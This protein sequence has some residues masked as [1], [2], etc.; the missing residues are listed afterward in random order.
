MSLLP[1]DLAHSHAFIR[2]HR[3]E[4]SQQ[5]LMMLSANGG[6]PKGYAGA[7]RLYHDA[8]E[9]VASLENSSIARVIGKGRP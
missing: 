1:W 5:R 3:G 2:L 8:P 4:A 7:G 9:E 6:V